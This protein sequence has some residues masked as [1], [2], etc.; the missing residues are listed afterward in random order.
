MA[1]L[2]MRPKTFRTF[3]WGRGPPH[4][5]RRANKDGGLGSSDMTLREIVHVSRGGAYTRVSVDQ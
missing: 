4:R 3:G 1:K 5:W 2:G